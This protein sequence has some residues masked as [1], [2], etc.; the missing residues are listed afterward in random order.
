ML[1]GADEWVRRAASQAAGGP[2]SRVE[3]TLR[4]EDQDSRRADVTGTVKVSAK[5]DCDR[6]GEPTEVDVSA[7]VELTYA[8]AA[9]LSSDSLIADEE[10]ELAR[11][12]LDVGWYEGTSL[13]MESV[14]CE[15]ISLAWPSRVV[16]SDTTSCEGRVEALLEPGKAATSPFSALRGFT[17]A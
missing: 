11:A 2:V 7:D 12:D 6:C 9:S 16:C 10:V 1:S 8:P 14:L 5:L 3:G 15:A 13:N 17:D 4:V